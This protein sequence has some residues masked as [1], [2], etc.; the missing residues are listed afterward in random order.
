MANPMNV[1]G[2]A[3][4]EGVMMRSPR[5]LAIAVRRANGEIVLTE[6]VWESVWER[7]K[8][9]R[10]PFV[11]GGIVL[12]EALVNGIQALM[13]SADQAMVGM[14]EDSTKAA[15]EGD[16]EAKKA[17]SEPGAAMS[18]PMLIG[19]IVFSLGLAFAIFK[20]IPHLLTTLV[21][22]NTDQVLFHVIDGTVKIAM[23]VGYVALIGRM[24][25]IKRVFQYH[26]AEHKSIYAFENGEELT[27]EN[28]KK[29]TTLH[30]RCG[31]SFIIIVLLSS[32]I[33]FM[34]VFPFLPP[35][36]DNRLVN[37]LLQ[38]LVKLPLMLPVAG[39]S[40]EFLRWSAKHMNN[41]VVKLLV[42]P[43]LWLQLITTQ[44]PDDSQLEVALVALRKALWRERVGVQELQTEKKGSLEVYG[45]LAEVTF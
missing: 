5:S 28:A 43:G 16:G 42:K 13:F 12:I 8:F 18:R 21:G 38:I 40:Y 17:P 32:I 37:A 7:Y 33:V 36:H 45:S 31:T 27:V 10:W 2:Q 11:R 22:L 15:K 29:Y 4:I 26:G 3:V 39:V 14:E 19:T 44:E 34:V 20:G 24:R 23:F 9:L 6:R 41:P 30:P 25:D 1:G 35:F